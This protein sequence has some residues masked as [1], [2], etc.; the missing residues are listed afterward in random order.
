MTSPQ[1]IC[2][3]ARTWGTG[4]VTLYSSIILARANWRKGDLHKC[5]TIV[6]IDF[7]PPVIYGLS[8]MK[9]MC[10]TEPDLCAGPSSGTLLTTRFDISSFQ[11]PWLSSLIP[12]GDVMTSIKTA[13]EISS[14]LA[15]LRMLVHYGLLISYGDINPGQHRFRQLTITRTN[16]DLSSLGFFGIHLRIISHVMFPMLIREI[17]LK[18]TLANYFHIS[19]GPL[20]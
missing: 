19:Q 12:F 8:C 20:N 18:I 1:L 15:L 16:V 14:H 10:I 9:N 7:S 11:F 6:N 5:I 13:N 3:V 4:T 17:I 2:D